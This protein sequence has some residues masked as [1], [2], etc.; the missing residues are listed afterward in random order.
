LWEKDKV[1]DTDPVLLPFRDIP[2]GRQ[3]GAAQPQGRRDSNKYI[4]TDLYAKA[5]QGMPAEAAVKWA[6][7]RSPRCMCEVTARSRTIA[8]C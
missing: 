1:W 6:L 2:H 3:R 7:K 4:I 5:I 8:C